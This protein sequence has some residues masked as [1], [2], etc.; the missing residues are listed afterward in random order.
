VAGLAVALCL[1]ASA[2]PRPAA[3]CE[4]GAAVS[5][6]TPAWLGLHM[7]KSARPLFVLFTADSPTC[8][9][10]AV[11]DRTLADVAQGY[12]GLVTFARV[13]VKAGAPASRRLV[14]DSQRRRQAQLAHRSA[15]VDEAV[16]SVPMFVLTWKEGGA[17]RHR[18]WPD[19][20]I[21]GPELEASDATSDRESLYTVERIARLRPCAGDTA[22]C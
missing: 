20:R 7:A 18:R 12:T 5:F 14:P 13:T 22:S 17:S 19:P 11:A 9:E 1:I 15:W 4:E 8:H 16:T 2:L 6:V 21:D 10:C 3:A